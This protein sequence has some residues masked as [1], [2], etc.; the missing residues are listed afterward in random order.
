MASPKGVGGRLR[1]LASG[2]LGE[3]AP[4]RS[5]F[6]SDN[7]GCLGTPLTIGRGTKPILILSRRPSRYDRIDEVQTVNAWVDARKTDSAAQ[8]WRCAGPYPR[9]DELN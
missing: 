1:A 2:L 9:V 7:N 6:S 8:T 3:R 5:D 4:T